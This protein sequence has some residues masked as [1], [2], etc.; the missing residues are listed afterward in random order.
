MTSSCSK[1]CCGGTQS[2]TRQRSCTNPPP[3]GKGMPCDGLASETE[4]NVPCNPQDCPREYLDTK[5]GRN[6]LDYMS[7]SLDLVHIA[8]VNIICLYY[9]YSIIGLVCKNKCWL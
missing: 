4:E 1:S 2:R 3:S 7:L 9:M 6:C 5:V 8:F